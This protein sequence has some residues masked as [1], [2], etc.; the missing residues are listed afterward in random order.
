MGWKKF[1]LGLGVGFAGAYLLK[2]SLPEQTLSAEK[3]LKL[4]KASFK[5]NGPISGSW[6]HMVPETFEK[7]NIS[8]SVYKGGISRNINNEL[9]QYEF[10][11]DAKTGSMLEVNPI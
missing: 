8:Y 9:K 3:A 5:K 4:A 11:I 10:L 1:L 6:I 2:G 7:F